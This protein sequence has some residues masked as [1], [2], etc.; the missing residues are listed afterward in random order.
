MTASE[1]LIQKSITDW[2]SAKGIFWRKMHIGPVMRGSFANPRYSA[3]PMRGYP[4]LWGFVPHTT[5]GEMF[6]IEVKK[7][8]TGKISKEQAQ[9]FL[10]LRKHG[11][12]Y[13][14]ARSLDDVIQAFERRFG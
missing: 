10:D 11:V 1:S 6:T 3:N 9:W 13:I 8:K 7:P 12:F 2:L 4:D 14:E 5:R